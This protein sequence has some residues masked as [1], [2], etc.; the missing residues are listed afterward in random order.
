MTTTTTEALAQEPTPEMLKAGVAAVTWAEL[1]DASKAFDNM[2]KI[3][4][5]M[6]AAQPKPQD[7]D[8]A[9]D[10]ARYRWLAKEHGWWLLQ[11]FPAQSPYS[12]PSEVIDAAIDAARGEVQP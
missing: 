9:R 6:S 2:R 11:H 3:W 1:Q 10:A 5:A 12:E 8:I 7:A 4:L